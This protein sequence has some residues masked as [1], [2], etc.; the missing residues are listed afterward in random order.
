MLSYVDDLSLTVTSDSHRGTIRRLQ[1]LLTIISKKGCDIR[2]SFS[3]PKSELIHCGTPSQ[4]TPHSK[5]PISLDWSLFHPLRVMRWLG[6]WLSPSF[7]SSHYFNHQ[8]SLANARFSFLKRISSPGMG[9]QLFLCHRITQ[10]LLLPILTYGADLLTRNSRLLIGM[11]SLWHRVHWWVTNVFLSTPTSGSVP[12]G[13][14]CFLPISLYCKY[15]RRLVALRI[16][17]APPPPPTPLLQGSPTLSP[18]S[19]SSEPKTPQGTTQK[20]SHLCTCLLQSALGQVILQQ[21]TD[22]SLTITSLSLMTL[23]MVKSS[24]TYLTTSIARLL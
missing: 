10:S 20:A 15:E 1:F 16:P 11:N 24:D 17:C 7:N 13:E 9:V 22:S 8:L 4:R 21:V 12:S 19:L 3:V 2:V 14:T 6:Y 23:L 18:P 5:T